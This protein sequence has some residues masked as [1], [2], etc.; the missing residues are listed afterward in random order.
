M[1]AKRNERMARLG[2][3]QEIENIRIEVGEVNTHIGH[4]VA[5]LSPEQLL[6]K[7]RPE[8][9]CI[10]DNLVHLRLT[11]DRCLP[12]VDR[13]IGEARTRHWFSDGPFKAGMMGRFFV[14]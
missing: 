13:A 2:H 8:S 9:W 11:V 12:S 3:V 1:Y 4:L 14:W 10:R 7:P 6:W 5:D